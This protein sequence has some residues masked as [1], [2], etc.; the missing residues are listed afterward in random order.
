MGAQALRYHPTPTP[1]PLWNQGPQRLI[2]FLPLRLGLKLSSS[3]FT[4]IIAKLM[5]IVRTG[6][7]HVATDMNRI[8]IT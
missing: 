2:H 3:T 7:S 4:V 1:T 6:A 5:L 8:M